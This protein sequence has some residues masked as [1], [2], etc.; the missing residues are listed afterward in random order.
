MS[1]YRANSPVDEDLQ[2]LY[3]DV[4]AGFAEDTPV[5]QRQGDL[6]DFYN[7]YSR[8]SAPPIPP[9]PHILSSPDDS[10][11]RKY[12]TGSHIKLP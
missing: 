11:H 10:H 6:D 12:Q 7:A 1:N 8:E 5:R 3:N 9:K 4:L 2:R